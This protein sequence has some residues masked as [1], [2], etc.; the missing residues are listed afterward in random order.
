[1][2]TSGGFRAGVPSPLFTIRARGGQYEPSADGQRF[3]INAGSGSAALP[4]T[5]AMNWVP[6][7][8]R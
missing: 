1:V 4:I 3:L 7:S 6:G 2:A 5:V 8:T